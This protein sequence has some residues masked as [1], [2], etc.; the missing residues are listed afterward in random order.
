MKIIIDIVIGRIYIV[1]MRWRGSHRETEMETT[2][3]TCGKQYE[4]G[5]DAFADLF[6]ADLAKTVAAECDDCYRERRMV[7]N[8][9]AGYCTQNHADCTTCSLVSYGRDCHNNAVN[10]GDNPATY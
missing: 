8:R 1:V 2:C 6:G 5:A 4:S 7:A 3:G 10:F 9:G